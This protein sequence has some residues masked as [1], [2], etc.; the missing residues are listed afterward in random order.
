LPP[1]QN[2]D[3]KIY[4]RDKGT[5]KLVPCDND[6]VFGDIM[7]KQ[8]SLGQYSIYKSEM[9]MGLKGQSYTTTATTADY[10]SA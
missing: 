2:D 8:D 6:R 7:K 9:T 10:K 5:N 4:R 1:S 3:F